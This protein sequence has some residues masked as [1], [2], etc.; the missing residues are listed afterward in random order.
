MN[1]FFNLFL[2]DVMVICNPIDQ[3]FEYFKRHPCLMITDGWTITMRAI[4][5]SR[6]AKV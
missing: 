4:N 3:E 6:L 2:S 1:T 5:L